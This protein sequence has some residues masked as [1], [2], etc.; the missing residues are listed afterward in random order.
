MRR[1]AIITGAAGGMGAATAN[2]LIAD[3]YQ[4]AL[5]DVSEMRVQDLSAQ[6][7]TDALPLHMDVTDE[8][9]VAS[10]FADAEASLGTV[11][12][13]ICTAGG[14]LATK[15]YQPTLT[16][17]PLDDWIR[18][19]ALNSRG[20]FLCVREFF[21]LRRSNPVENGR[22]VLT[23]SQ[24]AHGAAV[25]GVGAAYFASKAAVISICRLAALEGAPFGI[26]VNVISP[27]GFETDAFH[28]AT[29]EDKAKKQVASIPLGRLGRPREFADLAAFL[30][31]EEAG[32]ITGATLDLNGGSRMA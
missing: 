25:G 10:A 11:T 23:A 17:L 2:R 6:L 14:S 30:L 4:V 22:V 7:G 29:T 3:G 19:E 16:D 27:G 8:Q 9:S 5:A 15:S 12:D 13:L 32:Y 26:T 24:A 20:S 28:V 18:T 31:S 21:R 1:T